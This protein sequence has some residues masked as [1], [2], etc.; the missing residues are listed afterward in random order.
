MKQCRQKLAID[1]PITDMVRLRSKDFNCHHSKTRAGDSSVLTLLW[2]NPLDQKI[3]RLTRVV[4][5]IE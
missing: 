3:F 1:K 2:K 5:L 4:G